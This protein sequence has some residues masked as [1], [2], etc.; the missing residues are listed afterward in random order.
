MSLKTN[1]WILEK[2]PHQKTNFEGLLGQCGGFVIFSAQLMG[3]LPFS[4]DNMNRMKFKWTSLPFCMAVLPLVAVTGWSWCFFTVGTK[5]AKI[6]EIFGENPDTDKI[7]FAIVGVV[8][9]YFSLYFRVSEIVNRKEI[10][11]FWEKLH[12]T[13]KEMYEMGSIE[14]KIELEKHLKYKKRK[15]CTVLL[16]TFAAGIYYSISF[17]KYDTDTGKT[18]MLFGLLESIL[19]TSGLL[20]WNLHGLLFIIQIL[21][22]V[23]LMDLIAIGFSQMAYFKSTGNKN[24]FFI[25]YKTLEELVETLNSIFSVELT[26]SMISLGIYFINVLYKTCVSV[27]QSQVVSGSISS[28]ACGVILHALAIFL[29]CSSA[30]QITK[31]VIAKSNHFFLYL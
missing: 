6:M 10:F 4:F 22:Y 19:F 11:N 5:T 16:I 13:C 30:T 14:S 23:H 17:V 31:E 15:M 26:L 8:S 21:W 12:L 24:L 28:S 18:L 3:F 25:K 27:F 7:S 2:T 9:Y 29:L 1:I 20:L